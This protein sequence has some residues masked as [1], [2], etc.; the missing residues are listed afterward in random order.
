M[1]VESMLVFDTALISVQSSRPMP[2]LP[3]LFVRHPRARRYIIR[4][5]HDG[6]VRV[7]VPR[8]G[9]RR[10]AQV[11]AEGERQWIERQQRR[12]E[13]ERTQSLATHAPAA[14]AE[15]QARAR[16]ELPEELLRLA[17]LNGLRVTRISIRNQRWRWGSC[18]PSGHICLNWRLVLVPD[19]VREYVL[20]HE[21]MHLQRLDHSRAFWK[22]V[23]AAF[24]RT[25][26]ARRWLR[27]NRGMLRG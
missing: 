22:L 27:A 21:L 18:S 11:F 7:T 15:L 14:I 2:N 20:V 5:L 1:S 26:E 23:T 4:V 24:P 16:C 12:V 13:Q 17:R 9:S 3:L 25:A 8:W 10:G 19:F 6:T